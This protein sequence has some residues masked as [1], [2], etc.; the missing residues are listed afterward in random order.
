MVSNRKVA[1]TLLVVYVVAAVFYGFTLEL[2]SGWQARGL[3]MRIGLDYVIKALVSA[4]IVWVVFGL[5]RDRRQAP[6][7]AITIL[8]AIPFAYIWQLCYYTLADLLDIGHLDSYGSF[9]DIYIPTL[10]YCIQ[11]LILFA[12][13]YHNRTLAAVRRA[14]LLASLAETSEL[15]ALKA[16]VNPHF[17]FN[18]FNAISASLPPEQEDTREL[19]AKLADLFRYQVVASQA[20]EVPLGKELQFIGDYLELSHVRMGDRLRYR[21]HCDERIDPRTMVAPMLLQPLVE[22]A[23]AHGLSPKLIGGT[24]TVTVRPVAGGL[25]FAVED[26]G[27]GF[28]ESR[29]PLKDAGT[30]VGLA[31]TRRRLQLK[32]AAELKIDTGAAIGTRV[33]YVLPLPATSP[34]HSTPHACRRRRWTVAEA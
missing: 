21:I 4:P 25:S 26:S 18:T 32:Y 1:L 17:L 10:V 34:G 7:I 16:Q 6:Q 13:Q 31:N 3:P 29:L 24:L 12:V 2:T 23:L 5:L 15:A 33:S 28:D 22:N 30:G 20:E 11:F 27:V 8:M 19:L 14:E 9:W